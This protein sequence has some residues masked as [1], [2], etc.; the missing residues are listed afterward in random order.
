M[1]SARLG[2]IASVGVGMKWIDSR[3]FPGVIIDG[4]RHDGSDQVLTWD[5]GVLV[6]PRWKIPGTPL[7]AGPSLGLSW[8]N[9]AEDSIGY[10]DGMDKDPVHRMRRWGVAGEISAQDI[11]TAQVFLDEQVDLATEGSREALEYVGW[12]VEGLGFYR[13]SW[14]KLTDPAGGRNDVQTSDQLTF[15]LKQMWRLLWRVRNVDLTTRIED[16]PD[17]Y[18]MPKWKVLGAS[19]TPNVRVV[20]TSSEIEG[21]SYHGHVSAYDGQKRIAWSLCL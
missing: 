4:K 6:A 5:V 10:I 8:V 20:W 17:D 2:G 3:M 16:A 11:V 12:S 1:L 19:I 7:R 15:D 13:R 9:I 21:R 14:A 18:P